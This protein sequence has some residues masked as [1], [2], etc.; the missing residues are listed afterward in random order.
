VIKPPLVWYGAKAR[1]LR[2]LLHFLPP[3]D[4]YVE[5]FGGS[6]VLL[7]AKQ[8]SQIEVYNDIDQG[9]VNFFQVL[10]NR[11]Q[12]IELE[13]LLELTPYSRTEFVQAKEQYQECPDPVERARMFF[14]LAEM[15]FGGVF[16]SAWG[17]GSNPEAHMPKKYRLHIE[18][19]RPAIERLQHVYI[20]NR[21]FDRVIDGYDNPGTLFYLDPPYLPETWGGGG[22][23]HEMT[24]QQHEQL[25]D[26]LQGIKGMAMLS[27]YNSPLY[28]AK[29]A[30]WTKYPINARVTGMATT[31]LTKRGKG[32]KS[33]GARVEC[34]WLNPAAVAARNMDMF[35]WGNLGGDPESDIEI[36]GGAT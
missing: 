4:C 32:A 10:R 2:H 19:I 6:A 25:L 12:A 23:S 22:Y 7:C 26:Q 18:R 20:D 31:R 16:G 36:M 11:E 28:D 3:H 34:I 33:A 15:G 21:S 1:I 24:L 17:Y 14:I 9:L 8:P 5:V 30:G 27:G 29:L 35:T 13:R